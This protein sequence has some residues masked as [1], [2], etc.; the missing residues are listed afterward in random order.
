VGIAGQCPPIQL[1]FLQYDPTQLSCTLDPINGYQWVYSRD[2]QLN[3]NSIFN[4]NNATLVINGLFQT[5]SGAVVTIT[6]G[7]G[8]NRGYLQI[9]PAGSCNGLQ[10]NSWTLSV[11]ITADF[12]LSALALDMVS[13]PTCNNLASEVEST[14]PQISS[15]RCINTLS[16]FNTTALGTQTTT[17]T[18]ILSIQPCDEISQVDYTEVVSIGGIGVGLFIVI[19]IIGLVFIQKTA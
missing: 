18:I 4:I 9:N 19:A 10:N 8:D 16:L 1:Q 6:I 14:L 11:N 17:Q 3:D 2:V 7:N 13:S 5:T 15:S 12:A